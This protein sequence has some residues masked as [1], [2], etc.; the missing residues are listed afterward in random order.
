MRIVPSEA[1][2]LSIGDASRML[3]SGVAL[4]MLALSV[5]SAHA[6]S[7]DALYKK[8]KSEGALVIYAG[9]PTAPWEMAGKKFSARYP[10]VAVKIAGGFSNDLVKK[11][12]AQTKIHK[13]EADLAVLQTLQEI[14]RWKHAG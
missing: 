1:R 3:I 5:H 2:N 12:D 11:I 8:A 4:A 14:V 7:R 9:G 10:G 13:P 6:Q